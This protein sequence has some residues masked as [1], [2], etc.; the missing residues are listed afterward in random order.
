MNMIIAKSAGFCFGVSRAVSMVEEELESG[1]LYTLGPVIH[2]AHETKRLED[3]GAVILDDINKIKEGDRIVIRSH[4]ITQTQEDLIKS[5]GAVI[6]DATCPFVKKIHNIVHEYYSK[7]YTIVIVGDRNHPEVLGILGR[8]E[9]NAEVIAGEDA[10]FP[11][12]HDKN[13]ICIVAQ[14]T[15]NKKKYENI[16]KNVKNTCN[17]V[18]FFD[19]ICNATRNRQTEAEKLSKQCDCMVV[20]GDKSSRNTNELVE[21]IRKNLD[22]VYHVENA[23]ELSHIDLYGT[24]GITAGASAPD[25]IIKEV[26]K[27]MSENASKTELS[28]AE[29]FEK[30]LITLNTGD[31][32]KGT[33]IGITPTEVYVNLGYK[34]DGVISASELTDDPSANPDDIVKIGDEIE[35]YVYRVSD[36]EGTVGLSMKKLIAMK[37]WNELQKAFEEQRDISG[38]IVEVVNGGVIAMS[39]GSRVFIPASQAND[40]YLSDLSVLVGKEV[41][42]R[43]RDINKNRR[44]VVG[45][46][47]DVLM[48]QKSVLKKEFWDKIGAGQKQFTGTVKTLTNFGAFVD[49]GGVDGLVHISELSWSHIKH[50]SDVLTVGDEIEVTILEANPETEKISLG[51]KK[52]EDNPWAIAKSKLNVGDVI[53]VKVVRLVQFGAFVEIFPGIDGLIHI[54]QIANKRVEKPSD[55]LSIGQEVEV[56]VADINWETQKIAL[57]MRALL[58]QEQPA[59]AAAEE[60]AAEN[61]D[62]LVYSTDNPP[63]AA[64]E[65]VEEIK[66]AQTEEAPESAAVSEEAAPEEAPAVSQAPEE[67]E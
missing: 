41:P 30:S 48:E 25:W 5:R 57:S 34:A 24:I 1:P 12:L 23:S 39:E 32:V 59:E 46:V 40:R 53:T 44:R 33:V 51:Y 26:L 17:E 66:E 28:F 6:Y 13:K 58:P 8:C 22:N 35:A 55:E 63:E 47:K 2:N 61:T 31:V 62:S 16:V 45:S 3:M 18:V 15:A 65:L 20:I 36:V 64:E 67:T 7:G 56:Q 37:G 19:T 4:G 60:A 21:V 27:T 10:P 9:N 38:K 11:I 52:T 49:L 54:S 50:P 14:T 43:L 42:I 29:E